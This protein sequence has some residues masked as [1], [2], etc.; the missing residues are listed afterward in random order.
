MDVVADIYVRHPK[1]AVMLTLPTATV[2]L[3]DQVETALFAVYATEALV[4]LNRQHKSKRAI[5]PA[6]DAALTLRF[7]GTEALLDGTALT[8]EYW[9]IYID[10]GDLLQIVNVP[11]AGSDH[12]RS[13][14]SIDDSGA[15]LAEKTEG[16]KSTFMTRGGLPR[17]AQT[18]VFALL[19]VLCRKRR[20]DVERLRPLLVAAG[21]LASEALD[22][23]IVDRRATATAA[24]R[25]AYPIAVP[26]R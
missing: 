12:F 5:N 15:L 6:V 10:D 26:S 18:S 22:P 13:T 17:N 19:A 3:L 21:K 20:P 8:P 1:A 25:A 2:E 16:L 9:G 24:F 7:V 11:E 14:V 4:R 23:G